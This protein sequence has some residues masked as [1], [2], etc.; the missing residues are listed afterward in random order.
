M[1]KNL[2]LELAESVQRWEQQSKDLEVLLPAT[3]PKSLS[4]ITATPLT[5]LEL[6]GAETE[7]QLSSLLHSDKRDIDHVQARAKELQAAFG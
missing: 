7:K 4:P 6:W 3:L 5:L 2:G 1:I